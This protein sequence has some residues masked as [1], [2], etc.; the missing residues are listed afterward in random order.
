[1]SRQ[2]PNVMRLIAHKMSIMIPSG[3]KDGLAAGIAALSKP[4]NIAAVAREA[5]AWVAQAIA[6]VR[7]A[8]PPNP[9]KDADDEAIA[10]EILRQVEQRKKA[11]HDRP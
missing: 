10:D 5:T 7:Q 8:A 3:T 4:G 6:L 2:G 1:M 9:W 11:T